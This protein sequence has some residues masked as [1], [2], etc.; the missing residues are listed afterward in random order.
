M[1]AIMKITSKLPYYK[2]DAM[3]LTSP[4]GRLYAT[5]FPSTAGALLVTAHEACLLADS[6]YFEAA[7]AAVTDATVTM[8]GKDE[9]INECLASL[10]SKKKIKKLGFEDGAVTFSAYQ[11]M[12]K[13]GVKLVQAQKLIN[14]LRNIKSRDELSKMIAAQR[15]AEKVYNEILTLISSDIT[16]KEL[17]AE[18]IYRSLK[19]GAEKESFPPIVVSGKNSSLPHGVPGNE[20]IGKGFLTIDFGVSLNGWC[21]DTTRTVC[22]GEPDDEMVKIYNTVLEA[23]LAGI[24]TIRAGVKGV[25]VDGAARAVIEKAGY[26]DY[27]GHGFSHSIGLEVHEFL[28]ASPLSGDIL[29]AGAV[30]SAEPGIYIPGRYG[31]RIEDIL[32]ITEDGCENIVELPKTLMVL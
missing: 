6:R 20:K 2:I 17:A 21:S 26:G 10:I 5:G 19:Y 25:D 27:F 1:S 11:K 22:V 7:K 16:E 4:T 32:Y 9:T 18:F 13:F 15:L 30:I 29:P 23:Q 28:K 3:L 24:A 14:D 31:V 8:V 12:R